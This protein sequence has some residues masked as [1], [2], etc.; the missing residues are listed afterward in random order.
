M[1]KIF[2]TTVALIISFVFAI[3]CTAEKNYLNLCKNEDEIISI[4]V[5]YDSGQGK[6]KNR[7]YDEDFS[8]ISF[9]K[10]EIRYITHYLNSMDVYDDGKKWVILDADSAKIL[11]N[12][13]DGTQDVLFFESG[14]RLISN[15]E[16]YAIVNSKDADNLT[17]FIYA[18]K[19]HELSLSGE[20]TFTPS[21]W[22]EGYVTDAVERG[23]VP[24]LNQ[25]NYMGDVTRLEVCQL[26]ASYLKAQGYEEKEEDNPFTDTNDSAV[27]L[28]YNA[29]VIDGK[30]DTEFYPYDF[31]TREELAK[32][33]SNLYALTGGEKA[34][35]TYEVAY[36]DSNEISGWATEYVDKMSALGIL[37][38]DEK[39]NFNPKS[40]T[41][42]EQVI[43]T[44]LRMA[45]AK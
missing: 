40:N 7:I 24:R 45:D 17:R 34:E 39:G 21:D 44:L 35:Q 36:A 28:L 3:I 30:S 11:L 16:E 22:A 12:K 27:I 9:E 18:L 6:T 26:A 33:L 25:I 23:Y 41:T 20:I 1:K 2:V 42:K 5:N 8:Y 31:I 29:G 15:G 14:E 32:V 4:E 38:G 43:I 13:I 19:T 10:N 37:K